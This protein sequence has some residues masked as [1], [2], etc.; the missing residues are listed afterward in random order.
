MLAN[1]RGSKHRDG[2]VRQCGCCCAPRGGCQNFQV[3]RHVYGLFAPPLKCLRQIRDDRNAGVRQAEPGEPFAPPSLSSYSSFCVYG[4]LRTSV[5]ERTATCCTGVC[6]NK[7]AINLYLPR[8][9]VVG[10]PQEFTY[11]R[12]QYWL[13]FLRPICCNTVSFL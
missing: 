2:L 1:G 3:S 5:R 9:L 11:L 10:T 7:A 6:A 4:G 8:L 12:K 13:F